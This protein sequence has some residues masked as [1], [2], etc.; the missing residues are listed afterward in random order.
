MC[1]SPGEGTEPATPI[2]PEDIEK[3]DAKETFKE[4]EGMYKTL[5]RKINN[6]TLLITNYP[7]SSFPQLLNN[8]TKQGICDFAKTTLYV[9]FHQ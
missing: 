3:E 4:N 8:K 9:R 6:G 5:L 1:L 7:L 2:L